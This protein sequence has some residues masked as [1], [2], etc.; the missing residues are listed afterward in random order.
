MDRLIIKND[1]RQGMG[2]WEDPITDAVARKFCLGYDK[3][4]IT[5]V[6]N[7]LDLL[8]GV[9]GAE[10]KFEGP[11]TPLADDSAWAD[12]Y[13]AGQLYEYGKFMLE[14]GENFDE[15]MIGIV[16]DV[17]NDIRVHEVR[18]ENP[19]ACTHKTHSQNPS[20]PTL[21]E[22]VPDLIEV[23]AESS[24]SKGKGKGKVVETNDL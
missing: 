11:F 8:A 20:H 21:E 2:N 17:A 23:E 12:V 5:W 7:A 15:T 14:A 13:A 3:T 4:L 22:E 24:K 10:E 9:D 1:R 18:T 19:D 16:K 6:A